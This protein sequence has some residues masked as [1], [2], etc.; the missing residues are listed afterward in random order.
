MIYYA[1][2][3]I[4]LLILLFPHTANSTKPLAN[5]SLSYG[6][7][8][9]APLFVYFDA[10]ESTD[11]DTQNPQLDLTYCFDA[12]TGSSDE[13][14]IA[15]SDGKFINQNKST[16]CGGPQFAY[17]YENDGTFIARVTAIDQ[18]GNKDTKSVSITVNAYSDNETLCVGSDFNECPINATQKIYGAPGYTSVDQAVETALNETACNDETTACKRVLFQAG[19]VGFE[20]LN[21]ID[22][23]VSGVYIGA[24][25]SANESRYDV[26]ANCGDGLSIYNVT[27]DDIRLN[28]MNWQTT[29]SGV[30]TQYRFLDVENST[31]SDSDYIL[32]KN[33]KTFNTS[34]ILTEGAGSQSNYNAYKLNTN[35]GFF[36]NEFDKCAD[37]GPNCI[38]M[39]AQH[40]AFVGNLLQGPPTNSS[41]HLLRLWDTGEDA[42]SSGGAFFYANK[43]AKNRNRKSMLTIRSA[44]LFCAVAK[45]YGGNFWSEKTQISNNYFVNNANPGMNLGTGNGCCKT[46]QGCSGSEGAGSTVFDQNKYR[47]NI[48]EGNYYT[49]SST[50]DQVPVNLFAI[51]D[52]AVVTTFPTKSCNPGAPT[53]DTSN[54][55]EDCC[56]NGL[57]IP[58]DQ[59]AINTLMV[60]R[61]NV[62]S[63]LGMTGSGARNSGALGG[64]AITDVGVF[65]VRNNSLYGGE[66]STDN[67]KLFRRGCGPNVVSE[68]NVAWGE[69]GAEIGA[70]GF[71]QCGTSSINF[72]KNSSPGTGVA[73]IASCP[74]I[75][76]PA[77][78]VSAFDLAADSEIINQGLSVPVKTDLRQY[79][80]PG[81]QYWDPGAFERSAGPLISIP[82]TGCDDITCNAECTR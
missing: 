10:T 56:A 21:E 74:Y 18:E 15:N 32:L 78:D 25:G 75:S 44:G 17:V 24:Y 51:E 19:G 23:N 50:P 60:I 71:S 43:F 27:N 76:C 4:F 61:N 42:D 26:T 79:I 34:S 77:T 64:G 72:Q 73:Q 66:I 28:D 41:E 70:P 16:F 35:L 55:V 11:E 53:C 1:Q 37:G 14:T 54:Y 39:G 29:C 65:F 63:Y 13:Y 20:L 62:F 33:N 67:N 69:Y 47:N 31:T 38:F 3:L 59:R 48:F 8:A 2:A 5:L 46:G 80:R 12:G 45:G 36:E 49:M 81:A 52:D 57:I 40:W 68:N 30:G 6:A 7:T 82:T 22:V 9:K 58:A